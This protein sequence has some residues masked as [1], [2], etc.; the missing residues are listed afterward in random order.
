[1]SLCA[2]AACGKP[3]IVRLGSF[4][5]CALIAPLPIS[6]PGIETSEDLFWFAISLEMLTVA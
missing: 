6:K 5:T 1:L 4:A 2:S 3:Y